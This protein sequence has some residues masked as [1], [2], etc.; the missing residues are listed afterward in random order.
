M[1]AET[2]VGVAV[3]VVEV[4]AAA[5]EAAKERGEVVS[6][7]EVPSGVE[8]VQWRRAVRRAAARSAGAVAS[9]AQAT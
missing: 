9:V 7:G 1:T 4:S 6:A 5:A 8:P 3:G 2:P